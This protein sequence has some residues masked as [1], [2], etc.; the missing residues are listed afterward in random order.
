MRRAWTRLESVC[1]F[2]LFW[3]GNWART[4]KPGTGAYVNNSQLASGNF[5]A[6]ILSES[7]ASLSAGSFLHEEWKF[8]LWHEHTCM[9]LN[10]LKQ[11]GLQVRHSA[12]HHIHHSM[13]CV[14][15]PSCLWDAALGEV[16]IMS[17]LWV[18]VPPDAH[19]PQPSVHQACTSC[20]TSKRSKQS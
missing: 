4:L 3:G 11:P 8:Q 6:L 14:M 20:P 15:V 5:H 12:A 18:L 16:H 19:W 1:G 13:S 9:V 2:C 7:V 10:T 17:D